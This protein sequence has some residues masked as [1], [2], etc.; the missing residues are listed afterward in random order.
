MFLLFFS[1]LTALCFF[2]KISNLLKRWKH[3]PLQCLLKSHCHSKWHFT[4]FHLSC[5]NALLFAFFSLT[6][7]A[8]WNCSVSFLLGMVVG[9][10]TD[11]RVGNQ[12][13]SQT[14]TAFG[15]KLA[16][17]CQP[18]RHD[19]KLF[20]RLCLLSLQSAILPRLI[21]YKNWIH[22]SSLEFWSYNIL[23]WGGDS[24]FKTLYFLWLLSV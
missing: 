19:E 8:Q 9:H 4:R 11:Q 6:F 1:L 14:S 20:F 13:H 7:E 24:I 5:A 18:S 2:P 15:C 12:I 23:C 10:S 16:F 17:W 3:I 22:K 21:T